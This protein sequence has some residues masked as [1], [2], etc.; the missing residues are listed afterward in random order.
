[1]AYTPIITV[2]KSIPSRGIGEPKV[3]RSEPLTSSIPTVASSRPMKREIKAPRT[4]PVPSTVTLVRPKK[5][6]AKNSGEEK[7]RAT[8]AKGGEKKVSTRALRIPPIT[9]AMVAIPSALA[10]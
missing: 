9:E 8:W 1:M 7:L 5:T 4:D 2:R 3:N 6:M 10:A